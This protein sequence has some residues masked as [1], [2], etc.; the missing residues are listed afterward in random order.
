MRW[1][2]GLLCVASLVVWTAPLLAQGQ[3]PGAAQEE[4]V[5]VSPDE[6]DQ[7][8]LPAAP[9]VFAAYAFVWVALVSYVF[10]LWRRLTHVQRELAD[11]SA[12]L[13]SKRP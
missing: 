7:E 6:L 5:P 13:P 3:A 9:L 12:R 4:F 11:L 8:Q 10:V 2:A 1:I